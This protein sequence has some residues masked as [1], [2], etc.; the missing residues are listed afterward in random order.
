MSRSRSKGKRGERAA[1][2]L[3]LE[4]DF[5]VHQNRAGEEGEDFAAYKDGKR[6][7]VEVKHTQSLLPSMFTQCLKNAKKFDRMLMWR[8]SHWQM[9]ANLWVVFIWERG[10]VGRVAVWYSNGGGCD[11]T[12][13]TAR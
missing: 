9:P 10:C 6:W 11:D 2:L 13:G 4:R 8:P 7:S 3:L 5:E 1:K 12:Q